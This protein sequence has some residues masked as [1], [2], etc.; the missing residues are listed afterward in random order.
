MV[1]LSSLPNTKGEVLN[2]AV[3]GKTNVC[4]NDTNII[5]SKTFGVLKKNDFPVMSNIRR[6]EFVFNN[7][8][9]IE[10]KFFTKFPNLNDLTIRGNDKFPTVT[11]KLLENC[12]NLI[13]LKIHFNINLNHI[14]ENVLRNFPKL[15][16]LFIRSERMQHLRKHDLQ[17]VTELKDLTL[18]LT[19]LKKIDWNAFEP[20]GKL[21]RLSLM[22]NNYLKIREELFDWIPRLTE[23]NLIYAELTDIGFLKK[24]PRLRIL[25]LAGNRIYSLSTEDLKGL[26]QLRELD[27]AHTG[28]TH[29]E[30]SENFFRNIPKL[31]QIDITCHNLGTELFDIDKLSQHGITVTD[32]Y[33]TVGRRTIS[34]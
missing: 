17:I 33:A 9:E 15:E 21:E 20:I 10:P 29:I 26:N 4:F 11:K 16:E 22:A 31:Q 7:L 28:I 5:I 2:C 27:L 18:D 25:K 3:Y 24:L 34:C 13:R 12:K 8:T 19:T 14:E 32:K 30:T 6:M 1:F 23:L